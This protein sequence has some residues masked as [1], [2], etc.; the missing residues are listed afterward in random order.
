[1]GLKTTLGGPNNSA[2]RFSRSAFG[3]NLT[4]EGFLVHEWSVGD[5]VRIGSGESAVEMIITA[6]RVPCFKLG[7]RMGDPNFVKRFANAAR[8][9]AYGRVIKSGSVSIGDEFTLSPCESKTVSLR[10]ISIEWHQNPHSAAEIDRI[11]ATPV[12][13]VHR[14]R[15]EQWRASLPA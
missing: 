8:P 10:D 1:M 4:I 2:E 12:A 9:G 5:Q 15:L 13:S 14:S 6:P 11:L 3:E 7:L